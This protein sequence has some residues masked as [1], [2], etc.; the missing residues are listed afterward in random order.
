MKSGL[1]YSSHKYCNSL[2]KF[3]TPL[4]TPLS[5]LC[6]LKRKIDSTNFD[7]IGQYPFVCSRSWKD[8]SH[9]INQLRE[10]GGASV[11]FVTDPFSEKYVS[12]YLSTMTVARPF[13]RH[14]I[15]DLQKDWKQRLNGKKR[16]TIR[17]SLEVQTVKVLE[18]KRGQGPDFWQ[19]Y[20]ELILR[21]N[22]QGIQRLSKE[23]IS[24]QLDIDG[25]VWVEARVDSR[26]VGGMIW[27]IDGDRAYSH[28]HAQS[29]EGYRLHT[30]YALYY[31][32][33]NHLTALG[34][35]TASLGGIAGNKDVNNDGLANFKSLWSSR[36]K[37]SWL[38]GEILNR[39]KYDSLVKANGMSVDYF[40]GYRT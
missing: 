29:A 36:E 14:F 31:S 3:G 39:E 22:I 24:D 4:I 9:D 37:Y 17:Q 25:A 28:L 8:V 30:N 15:V 5:E 40:P 11:V 35:E 21:H 16:Y 38:C 1:G 33:L 32:A 19:L 18:G 26:L 13:K 10:T 34:I 7:Y 20:Q 2:A 6:F 27:Y 23:I 12:Q